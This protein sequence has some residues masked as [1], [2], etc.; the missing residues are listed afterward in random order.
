MAYNPLPCDRKQGYQEV[1]EGGHLAWFVVDA[2]EQLGLTEFY[3]AY[4][5]E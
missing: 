1:V 5:Y 4:R 3:A 2:V